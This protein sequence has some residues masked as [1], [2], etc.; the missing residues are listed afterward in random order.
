M[1]INLPEVLAECEAL[2]ER[3][4][5]ALVGND[6]E[7]AG[8]RHFSGIN[9]NGAENFPR[10]LILP[11]PREEITRRTTSDDYLFASIPFLPFGEPG[12]G[13]IRNGN[14]SSNCTASTSTPSVY[15]RLAEAGF[16]APGGSK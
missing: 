6:V 5:L 16:P 3:Y 8:S 10:P 2:V 9:A 11:S 4:G 1:D 13:G 14:L 15:G 7:V 12:S